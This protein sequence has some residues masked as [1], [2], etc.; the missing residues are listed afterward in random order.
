MISHA[1]DRRIEAAFRVG[2]M[3]G[4]LAKDYFD[5]R[6]E[7]AI[8]HKGL[9]DLVSLADRAV[10]ELIRKELGALFPDDDFL[11]EEGGGVASDRVWVIDPIDGT[12]NFLRGLPYWGVVLAYAVDGRPVIGVTHDPVHDELWVA[13]EGRGATRNG[14]PIHVS[15][16]VDPRAGCIGLSFNFKQPR[17]RYVDLIDGLIGEGFDHRRMGSS[18]LKLCHTADGRIDGAVSLWCNSWDVLAGLLLVTEAG[19]RATDYTDGC[20]RTD[21]RAVLACT[22][23]V[24][25]ARER[26]SGLMLPRPGSAAHAPRA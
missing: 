1:L 8:E 6:H 4:A 12:M 10:E 18:A 13:A 5:R 21:P 7:L 14:V 11:G 26:A 9:Q 20:S 24:A 19:G 23:S 22:P 15:G 16:L 25:D 2:R 17:G 3:A